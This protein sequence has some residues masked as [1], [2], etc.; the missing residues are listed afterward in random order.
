MNRKQEWTLQAIFENPVRADIEW[1]DVES[2]LLALGA[3]I[4]K[5]KGSRKR[6]AL[7]GVKAVMHEPH[8]QKEV[9]KKMVISIRD[10]LIEAEVSQY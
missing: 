2:L 7:N 8:P 5:G 3:E 9:G 6:V 1:R 10:F 4:T